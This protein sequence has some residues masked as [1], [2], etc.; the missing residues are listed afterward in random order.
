M[1]IAELID[2]LHE[3]DVEL[4]PSVLPPWDDQAPVLVHFPEPWPH[5]AELRE[6][7]LEMVRKQFPG[8]PVVDAP[9]GAVQG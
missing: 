1:T 6:A 8:R 9:R 7:L 4:S 2:H 5:P 3:F